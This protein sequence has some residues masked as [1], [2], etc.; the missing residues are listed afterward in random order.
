MR[1]GWGWRPRT[2]LGP[3]EEAALF[4][5]AFRPAAAHATTKGPSH[6]AQRRHR[7]SRRPS[8]T[9]T[10]IPHESITSRGVYPGV[11]GSGA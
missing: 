8:E 2:R 11:R 7:V 5:G 9:N 1:L 6:V 4:M 3:A 10:A